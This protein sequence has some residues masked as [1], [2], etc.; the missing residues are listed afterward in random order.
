MVLRQTQP[1]KS[2]YGP[3]IIS[4]NATEL[5]AQK[6]LT[7]DDAETL[8][9]YSCDTVQ[10]H[11]GNNHEFQRALRTCRRFL[12]SDTLATHK[13]KVELIMTSGEQEYLNILR[14]HILQVHRDSCSS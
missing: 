1:L 3:V 6:G 4:C 8:L 14:D 7:A 13:L 12:T 10:V 2:C 9:L 11:T 5:T